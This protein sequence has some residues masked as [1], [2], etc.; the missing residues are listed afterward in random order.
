MCRSVSLPANLC[1]NSSDCYPV[2]LN[3]SSVPTKYINCSDQKCVCSDCFYATNSYKSCAYQR[4]WEY[5]NITQTCN[6]LRK[7]QRTAF[8]LSLFL[9]ALGAANFY[10]EQNALG[11]LYNIVFMFIYM[12]SMY[13]QWYISMCQGFT[14]SFIYDGWV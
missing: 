7:D 10:I 1:S 5:D 3:G 9:S 8:F 6:D 2:G 12:V 4:C 13:Y 11:M 14:W